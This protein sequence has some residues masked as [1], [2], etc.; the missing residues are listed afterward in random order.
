M[1]ETEPKAGQ[2]EEGGAASVTEVLR[3]A[4]EDIDPKTQKLLNEKIAPQIDA[5]FA[6]QN[7]I[8]DNQNATIRELQKA[9]DELKGENER[10]H[11]MVGEDGN[12]NPAIEDNRSRAGVA[13]NAAERAR[14]IDETVP[15][16]EQSESSE[17]HADFD[18]YSKIARIVCMA[19]V[20]SLLV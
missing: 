12:A 14:R 5:M 16:V 4:N 8:I 2:T 10:L 1:A 13:I 11:K 15:K 17:S 19:K 9:L 6:K 20:V 3:N 18:Q 7:A